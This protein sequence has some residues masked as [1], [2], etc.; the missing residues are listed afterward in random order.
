VSRFLREPDRV[1]PAT[2]ERIQE[3]IS[4]TGYVRNHQAGQLASGYSRVIAALVPSVGTAIFAETIEGL[5]QALQGSGFEL[6]L[7]V[8]GYSMEREEAQ[9]RAFVGWAPAAVIVT[10]SHRTA[11]AHKVL[12][13]LR[14][15][16]T[17]VLEI[18]DSGTR[19]AREGLARIGFSH[20]AVGKAM[21]RHLADQGHQRLL[22]ADS[23]VLE[24]FRAHER[25]QAF[26]AEAE[27]L[28]CRC[29]VVTAPTG[30][31]FEAGEAVYRLLSTPAYRLHTGLAFANDHLACGLLLAARRDGRR[32]PQELS[33][34]GFGNFPVGAHLEPG[35]TTI[36]PPR[37]AI[38]RVAAEAALQ[39]IA[40]RAPAQ[41]HA[42]DWQLVVRGTSRVPRS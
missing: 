26:A 28:G 17:P 18:W 10:G 1:S 5:S 42:L 12:D 2:A 40:A 38:G 14:E 7:G 37:Q 21:A 24:D 13:G 16:G 36:D 23:G 15:G 27:R 35:L 19:R 30:D 25:G 41:S 39:A 31:P 11:G 9:L 22:Y 34:V 6:M 8:T 33:L 29:K 20:A 4:E 32:I 3:A